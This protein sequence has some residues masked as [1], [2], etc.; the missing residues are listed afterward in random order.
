MSPKPAHASDYTPEQ[1]GRVRATCLY[2]ATKLGDVLDDMVVVGGLV[3]SLIIP[4]DGREALDLTRRHVGTL[5]LDCGFSIALLATERYEAL[6]ERLKSAGFTEAPNNKG[7]PARFRWQ[8]EA[9]GKKVTVDF[10]VPP[11]LSDDKGG[12]LRQITPELAAV[13]TPGLDLAFQDSLQPTIDGVT[14]K[15]ERASRSFRVCGPGAFTVLKTLAVR[16]RGEN[17]DAY[18]LFYVLRN[19]GTGMADVVARMRPILPHA[20]AQEAL[21]ILRDDFLEIDRVGPRRVA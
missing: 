14:I 7:N 16:G 12:E 3:P 15:G 4:Q 13:I 2:L 21:Q 18:D 20:R 6:V 17:K 5:D 19:Y 11:S 9:D 1:A 8:I 10:L